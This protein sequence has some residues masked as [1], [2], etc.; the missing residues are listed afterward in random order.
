MLCIQ[1]V[2]CEK[3]IQ[4]TTTIIHSKTIIAISTIIKKGNF[5]YFIIIDS[6]LGKVLYSSRYFGIYFAFICLI[7]AIKTIW[8]CWLN[9]SHKLNI[10]DSYFSN[11]IN[12]KWFFQ[13]Y[14]IT[15]CFW[16]S[17][18]G[19]FSRIRHINRGWGFVS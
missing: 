8:I 5:G 16:G 12:L 14:R 2:K 10:I 9:I 11:T 7:M 4:I 15:L 3:W 1:W 17:L 19:R 13:R 6:F 18:F